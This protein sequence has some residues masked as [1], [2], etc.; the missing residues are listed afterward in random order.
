MIIYSTTAVMSERRKYS[1]WNFEARDET[2][3]IDLFSDAMISKN[4]VWIE[5]PKNGR[6]FVAA[7]DKGTSSGYM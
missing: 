4:M 5:P 3:A 1:I 6:V 2:I 7:F